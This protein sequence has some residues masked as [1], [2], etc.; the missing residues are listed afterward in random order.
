MPTRV[1][2]EGPLANAVEARRVVEL[3]VRDG[4]SG[5]VTLVTAEAVRTAPY[6][7]GIYARGWSV[8]VWQS[9]RGTNEIGDSESTNTAPHAR[10]LEDGR[11]AGATPP[12]VSAI[13]PWTERRGMVPEPDTPAGRYRLARRIAIRIGERGTPAHEPVAG[14]IETLEPAIAAAADRIGARI[15]IRLGA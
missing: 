12:P 13:A 9:H 5:V 1:T 2:I 14:A 10:V 8:P 11:R 6:D 3:L 4:G 15:A 7:Q